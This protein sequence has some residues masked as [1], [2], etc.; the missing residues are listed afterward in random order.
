M[1]KWI[2]KIRELLMVEGDNHTS[3]Y[4]AMS[5]FFFILSLIPIILLLLTLIQ[6]TSLTKVD[7]MSAVVRVVPDNISPTI[8]AIVNQV[9]NQS[10]AVIPVTIVAALWSAG[11]GFWQSLPV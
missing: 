5:A 7:V 6:Y 2:E 11:R 4:A 3:A 10:A 1:K 9:Y 8:L